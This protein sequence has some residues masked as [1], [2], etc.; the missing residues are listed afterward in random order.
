[1]SYVDDI[2]G[3]DPTNLDAFQ[4]PVQTA[5]YDANI[6]KTNPVKFSKSE[7]GHYRA[8]IKAIYNPN[9]PKKS[10]VHQATYFIKDEEGSLLVRSKLGNGDKSC[11]LFTSWKKLWFTED[12][13]KKDWAR[14]MYDKSESDWVLVQVLEDENQPELVGKF[15]AMKLPK[16]IYEKMIAKMKPSPESKKAP[17]PV[18]DYL[19]GLP[20]ELDVKPGPDDKNAPERKQREI[21]YDLCEFD[22]EY[23]PIIQ[24]NGE[25]LFTD[26]ELEQ[27]DAFVTARAEV[28]KGKSAAK[29]EAAQK[30]VEEM[31]PAIKELYKKATDYVLANSIDLV[32]E[33]G[34]QEWDEA[35]ATRVQKWIDS[36]AKLQ[37]PQNP[38]S[39]AATTFDAPATAVADAEPTTE[40]NM[41]DPDDLPF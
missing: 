27:I 21:S 31:M 26:E 14:K 29:R 39:N 8:K 11:P 18:M 38:V 25:P 32:K 23:A 12:Q 20:I 30:Q 28:T 24:V 6:Y 2:M 16:S 13:E 37:D 41:S 1:M 15:L 10:I 40:K 4:E 17:I 34:Y 3:F 7:D 22:T 19:V 35:T 9:D 36:V 5:S 33:C